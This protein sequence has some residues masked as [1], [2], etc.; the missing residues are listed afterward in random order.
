MKHLTKIYWVITLIL[1]FIHSNAQAQTYF[2]KRIYDETLAQASYIIG[3]FK[4]KEAIV[5]DPQRD[6]D[7]YL[8]IAKKNNLKIN[9]ITETHIHTD[10]LS[11]SRELKA[12]T[13]AELLLSSEGGTDWQ[14]EFPHTQL[15]EGSIIKIG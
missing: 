13:N 9:K 4:T 5:I 15:N 6:V 12:I 2:F 14:Y 3:D 7:I 11:G 8:D 1:F 10:F